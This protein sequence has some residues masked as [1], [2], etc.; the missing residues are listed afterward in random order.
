MPSAVKR[1]HSEETLAKIRA[2]R[3]LGGA[4]R[5]AEIAAKVRAAMSD[6]SFEIAGNGGV[7]PTNEGRV[8][9][10]ELARRSGIDESTLY[11]PSQE[12]LHSEAKAWRDQL[13]SAQEALS[14]GA[15]VRRRTSK[16]RLEELAERHNDV[17]NNYHLVELELQQA[18]SELEAAKGENGRL[19]AENKSLRA[20]LAD[21]ASGK[22][23]ALDSRRT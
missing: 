21:Y 13:V 4:A 20:E 18:Q 7:Y 11:K 3:K 10:A 5:T 2:K 17:V 15:S 19:F 22:V 9:F 1:K 14:K 6:I 8:S 23:V 12:Q 16:E